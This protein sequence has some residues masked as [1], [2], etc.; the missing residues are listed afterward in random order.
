MAAKVRVEIDTKTTGQDPEAI[1]K[2]FADFSAQMTKQTQ[3][4]TAVQ[5]QKAAALRE[6]QKAEDAQL[7]S[8]QKQMSAFAAVQ[9]QKA[10][11]L[12]AQQKEKFSFTELKSAIDLATMALDKLKQ[13]YDFAK[14]G[15]QI[16]FTAIKFDRLAQT[17]G[18]T[19]DALKDKLL[20]AT[21]GTMSEMQAMA[22]A[23]D[24]I[25]LGLVKTEADTI[26][27]SAVVSGLGMDMNQLVLALSN[28]TTMRF[29][30]LGVA[31]VGFDEKVKALEKTG[32]SAQDAFTEAFLQQAEEQLL[33]VGNAADTTAGQFL[34]FEAQTA[35]MK[36][37]LK[38]MAAQLAGPTVGALAD[39]IKEE[40]EFR[41]IL[42]EVNP[43]LYNQHLALAMMT[44]E[45][46]KVVE[47]Y[48]NAEEAIKA[49]T[50][51]VEIGTDR[52]DEMNSALTTTNTQL[53][54]TEEQLKA[55]DEA[56]KKF[57]STAMNVSGAMVNYREEQ[58]K[59]TGEY[60]TGKITAEEYGVKMGELKEKHQEAINSMILDMF[61]MKLAA[62]GTFDGVD[63]EKYLTAAEKLGVITKADRNATID[64]Y[65]EVDALD[66][67]LS[68]TAQPMLHV[69]ERAKDGAD[70]FGTMSDAAKELG[71][72]LR[73]DA[74][75]GASAVTSSLLS[76]PTSIDVFV[77]IHTRGSVPMFG[78]AGGGGA[79]QNTAVAQQQG[80][81]VF[82]GV[83]YNVG[84][85]GQETFVPSSNG[86]IIGHREALHQAGLM[87]GGG[88][89]RNIFYGPVTLQIGE[90]SAAGF[91]ALR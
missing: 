90:D 17:I 67:S 89:Q 25:S 21:K 8:M 32:M 66:A 38:V 83:P 45:M 34:R 1:A 47:E 4:F 16:E 64:L 37:E 13:G 28:Q 76:I 86:R 41:E 40:R 51:A 71:E 23:T 48:R 46:I 55:V 81:E 57:A 33:K 22:S 58:A 68:E 56:N 12:A 9:K 6:G 60:S 14:E 29:D 91:M 73:K 20:E 53:P 65:K 85:A 80:G 3:A 54:L 62:D 49:A 30:Q 10:A 27:L 88:S 84:E 82:A 15:A 61:Q 39:G 74:A 5:K 31:V 72:S 79:G 18:T 50:A 87:G 11:A 26:R 35:D 75:A 43:E 2:R 44:P 19:G 7:A 69:S 36:N 78:S 70:N 52:W 63:L 77:N 59:V 42:K 24:L